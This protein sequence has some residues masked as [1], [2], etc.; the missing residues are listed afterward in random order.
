MVHYTHGLMAGEMAKQPNE[1]L[2]RDRDAQPQPKETIMFRTFMTAAILALTVTAAQAQGTLTVRFGDLDM[3]KAKDVELFNA[4]VHDAAVT[5]C[6]PVADPRMHPT[7]YYSA[8]FEHCVY[9]TGNSVMT[10]YQVVAKATAA[11][12]A[13]LAGK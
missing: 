3:T 9:R 2:W 12:R 6:T 10:K 13:Q 4:R 5:A 11:T 8:I 7:L 1:A